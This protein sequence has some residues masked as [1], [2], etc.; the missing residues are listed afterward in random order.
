[1]GPRGAARWKRGRRRIIITHGAEGAAR[2][3]KGKREEN[4]HHSWGRRAPHGGRREERRIIIIKRNTNKLFYNKSG[5][6]GLQRPAGQLV[7]REVKTSR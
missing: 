7:G 2:W 6:S 3:R 5:E 4:H 1:M